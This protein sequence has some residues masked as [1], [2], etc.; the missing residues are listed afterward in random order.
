MKVAVLGGT[1]RTG[2]LLVDDLLERGQQVVMLVRDAK[3]A[4]MVAD[5]VTLI[6]GD[7]RDPDAVARTID[8]ANAIASALGPVGKDA[9]LL[10]DTAGIVTSAMAE[11]HISR[12]VGISVA[13]LTLPADRKR[14][15]DK[16]ISW[17]LNRLGGELAK[18]KIEEYS[19]WAHSGLDWTLARVPRLIDGPLSELD[20]DPHVSGR[21]TTL[22]RANLA[23]FLCDAVVDGR[24]SRSAP[25]LSDR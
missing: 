10:R 7:V 5:R 23:R 8:G 22:T 15:R 20:V 12:Y 17:L 6:E 24:Y 4:A 14:P 25:F 16:V 3:K 9:T 2:S 19:A 13:G 11:A 1:G 21:R 18:D